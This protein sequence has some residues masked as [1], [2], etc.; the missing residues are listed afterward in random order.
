MQDPVDRIVEQIAV[1]ADD[2]DGARIARQMVGKPERAFKIEIVGRLVEQQQVRLGEQHRGERDAHAPAAGKIRAG[3][4]LRFGVEA[5]AGQ[6]GG[7]ARGR[8]MR[9]DVGKPRLD[10]G[11]A[12][13]IVRG[14]GLGQQLGALLVGGEHDRR[15]GFPGRSAP[16]ARGGRCARAPACRS[17]HARRQARR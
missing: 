8:R 5:E 10:L 1:V 3:A 12:M 11:D 2:D 14:F 7:R 16:P 17:S 13:R 15:S 9:A 4:L 6:D